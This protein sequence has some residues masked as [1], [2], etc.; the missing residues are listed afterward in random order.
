MTKVVLAGASGFIGQNLYHYLVDK[1]FDIQKLSLR[2][3]NWKININNEA[4]VFVNLIGKAH[5]HNGLSSEQDFFYANYELTKEVFQAFLDSKAC[6]FVHLSSIAALE[7]ESY[8]RILDESKISNSKSPY[9]R[10]KRKAEEFLLNYELPEGK[11]VVIIRPTMVHGP[12]DKGNLTLLFKMVNK[13]IPYPLG[14]FDNERS[15]L[16]INNLCFVIE[17]IILKQQQIQSDIYNLAD[18]ESI[19]TLKII[20]TMA[21]SLNKK[22]KVLFLPT[23]FVVFIAR[24][25]DRIGLPLNSKRL[26]KMTSNLVVSNEKIK[27]A[28]D[29]K[30][31][32]FTAQQG[33]EITIKSFVEIKQ[34]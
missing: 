24:I 9:G 32:P 4:N 33:L 27:K 10:S 3:S 15:F 29:I 7:E 17:N 28:L 19:S 26:K 11:K 31:L 18:D 13:G 12:N 23:K 2:N 34:K 25:G 14:N 1:K 21:N 30:S 22:P 8:D 5:D 6:L 20:K 16:G